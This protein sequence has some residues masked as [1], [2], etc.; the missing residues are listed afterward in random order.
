MTLVKKE[1]KELRLISWLLQ[2]P[3]DPAE[4]IHCFQCSIYLAQ[5][6]FLKF[7]HNKGKAKSLE[8]NFAISTPLNVDCACL[9]ILVDCFYPS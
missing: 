6:V 5:K 1:L 8:S 4:D 9:S 3:A 2:K 7:Q